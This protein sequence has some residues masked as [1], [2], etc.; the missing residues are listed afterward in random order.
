VTIVGYHI[1]VVIFCWL[2]NGNFVGRTMQSFMESQWFKIALYDNSQ[3]V[4]SGSKKMGPVFHRLHITENIVGVPKT[5]YL[6]TNVWKIYP[7]AVVP[8]L[9]LA[10]DRSMHDNFTAV[11]E[12]SMT[13]AL[14]QQPKW[15]YQYEP[16]DKYATVQSASLLHLQHSH[17][18]LQCPHS[19]H[20][21]VLSW[22]KSTNHMPR[23]LTFWKGSNGADVPFHNN[24]IGN[25]IVYQDGIETDSL[26]LSCA[27]PENSEWFSVISAIIVGHKKKK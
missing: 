2:K 11:R 15:S 10:V 27:H 5:F 1:N 3:K 25:F 6:K 12:Y 20:P 23:Y 21:T 7:K 4:W 18:M 8:N 13:V 26:K 9:F 16:F 14:F 17:F 22:E 24:I 19:M